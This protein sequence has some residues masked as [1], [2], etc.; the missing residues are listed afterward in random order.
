MNRDSLRQVVTVAA[1][2]ATLVVNVLSITIPL[3]GRTTQEISDSFRVYVIP[4]GPTFAIWG[5]IYTLLLAFA[6][7][8]ARPGLRE[9][10]LLRRLGWL[11]VVACAFNSAW[12]FLWQYGFIAPSLLPMLGLL[13]TLIAIRFVLR[14]TRSRAERWLV[15]VPHSVYLGWITVATVLNVAV[16]LSALG[17]S[18]IAGLE[19]TLVAAAVLVAAIAIGTIATVRERDAAYGLIVAF[20]FNGIVAKEAA[21][22]YVGT[23]AVAGLAILVVAAVA[24]LVRGRLGGPTPARA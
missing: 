20:A 19:P 15:G 7:H 6:I 21:T 3:G 12:I 22:P 1:I 13:G 18:G 10:P 4:A 11:P 2:V 8:Q 24:V 5:L 17:V 9:D 23:V 16:A 14:D